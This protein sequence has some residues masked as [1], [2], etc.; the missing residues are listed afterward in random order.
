MTVKEL[1]DKLTRLND[2][3]KVVVYWE[4]GKPHQFF[5]IDDVS[6]T[7]GTPI[8]DDK[9]RAR[10]KFGDGPANWLFIGISPDSE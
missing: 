4:N 1:R 3:S 7:K 8:R 5:E 6:L 2:K 9:G 10:F